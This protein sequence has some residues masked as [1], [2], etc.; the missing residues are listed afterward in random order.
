MKSYLSLVQLVLLF[1]AI[2]MSALISS[3]FPDLWDS[4][5]ECKIFNEKYWNFIEEFYGSIN[6]V[7]LYFIHPFKPKPSTFSISTTLLEQLPKSMFL[8]ID[9]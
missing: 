5:N 1:H 8:N 9:F 7:S 4:K 3:E 6:L 2:K